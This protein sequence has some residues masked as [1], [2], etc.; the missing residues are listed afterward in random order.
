MKLFNVEL[1][2]VDMLILSQITL[3]YQTFT[4][5]QSSKLYNFKGSILSITKEFKI[6]NSLNLFGKS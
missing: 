5:L 1:S 4:K 2:T 3:S 6:F